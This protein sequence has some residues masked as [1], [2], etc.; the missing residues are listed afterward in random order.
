MKI[1]DSGMPGQPVWEGMVKALATDC[2]HQ[3]LPH[4]RADTWT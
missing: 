2:A 3:P 4:L 1:R